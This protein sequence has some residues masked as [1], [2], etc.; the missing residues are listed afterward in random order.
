MHVLHMH[1]GDEITEPEIIQGFSFR[2]CCQMVF[3]CVLPMLLYLY[4]YYDCIIIVS[5][6]FFQ[7]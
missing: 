5:D 1:P 3:Q 7:L 2:G 4:Y 6:Y